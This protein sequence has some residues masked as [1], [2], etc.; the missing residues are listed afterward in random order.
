MKCDQV[1]LASIAAN[2]LLAPAQH[3]RRILEVARR[4]DCRPV[5]LR[6]RLRAQS[7]RIGIQ[8]LVIGADHR[9][10]PSQRLLCV[11]QLRPIAQQFAIF[12]GGLVEAP[13]IA[14]EMRVHQ[15]GL[16]GLVAPGPDQR[17]AVFGTIQPSQSDG[18]RV[19]REGGIGLDLQRPPE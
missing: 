7:F 17:Q 10:Q 14:Q 12:C 2:R 8:G 4:R 18:H 15:Q 1:R 3:R 6:R 19:P 16:G 5:E 9:Q 13:Q 11:K